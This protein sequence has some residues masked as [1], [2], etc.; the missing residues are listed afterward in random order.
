LV[1]GSAWKMEGALARFYRQHLA[2]S[3]A[4]NVQELLAGL[5]GSQPD[6]PAHAVQSLDWAHATAGE[7]GWQPPRPSVRQPAR[8]AL[9]RQRH[10]PAVGS[11]SDVVA[12]PPTEPS[13][14]RLPDP[15]PPLLARADLERV[16]RAESRSVV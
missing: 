12:Q 3:L 8:A 1:G 10:R 5:P 16:E 15:A 9:H 11:T 13:P 7:L 6:L 4:A 14:V 2:A